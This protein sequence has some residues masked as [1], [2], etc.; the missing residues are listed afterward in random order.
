MSKKEMLNAIQECAA[1]L[2]RC[3][4]LN[5]L[6]KLK[7]VPRRT[8]QRYFGGYTRALRAAGID[9]RGP[10]RHILLK[11]LFL[12]WAQAVRQLGKI[13]SFAEYEACTGHSARPL[14]QRFA[15]WKDVP[16]GLLRF[17][18]EKGMRL[19]TEWNDVF[20]IARAKERPPAVVV[21][22]EP[23]TARPAPGKPV[24]GAALNLN[25]LAHS[26]TNEI[27][28]VYLFGM[29]A[30]RLGFIV[31][32]MQQ[33]FPDC[34]AML[35]VEKDQWQRLRLEFE[36]ESRNFL[37]HRHDADACDMIVCWEHNWPECPEN[38]D[39]LE[40]SRMVG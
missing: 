17:A 8:V 26:P 18:R 29:L 40:L 37:A 27:G 13:P 28:V 10:G 20:Q 39:V 24:Y 9:P 16:S 11:E 6:C 32:R 25:P 30:A 12:D 14:A 21:E 3:P 22:R 36:Y 4:T 15:G 1:K 35:Q 38:L 23:W 34:E 2:G 33:G 19:E 5:E 7:K 31:T